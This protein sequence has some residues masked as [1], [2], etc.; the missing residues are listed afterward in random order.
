MDAHPRLYTVNTTNGAATLVGTVAGFPASI[1]GDMA[2]NAS[3]TLYAT[4]GDS[5]SL[6]TINIGA[7]TSSLV[8]ATGQTNVAGM[9]FASGA[10]LYA[11]ESN[12]PD[13][14]Q[15]NNPGT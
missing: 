7:L 1:R 5:T 6:Y 15:T 8:G 11:V 4:A 13:D 14:L 10:K 12:S 3:G 9:A 2:F